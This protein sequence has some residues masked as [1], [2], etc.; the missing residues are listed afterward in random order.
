MT[1]ARLTRLEVASGLVLGTERRRWAKGGAE[2]PRA[3][4]ERSLLPALR[5]SPCLV[6]FS[7]GRDS[8]AV[9]AVATLVA[10][11]ESLPDPIPATLRF[12]SAAES[13]ESEWQEQVV[14]HLGLTDWIRI[15][16]TAELDCVGPV[17]TAALAEHGLLWPCN[18]H[19]HV[20][21]IESARGGSLL[22]GIGGDELL[23]P[24]RWWY[25]RRV[26]GRR[27]RFRPR[28]LLAIGLALAPPAL[29]RPVLRRKTTVPYPWLRPDAVAELERGLADDEAAEPFG[30]RR[31]IEWRADR[32]DLHVG[33][34]SLVA[35]GRADDV[36]LSHPLFGE[37]FASALAAHTG[38]SR[39]RSRQEAMDA[40]FGD[41]LP[42]PVR[43]R[44]TKAS[45]DGAFWHEHSR[46]LVARWNGD[47]VDRDLVDPEALREEWLKG[48][49][50]PRTYTLL[51]SVKL[52]VDLAGGS[53]DEGRKQPA[54]GLLEPPPAV[55]AAELPA[56]QAGEL[57]EPLRTRRRDAQA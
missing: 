11:R 28:D 2:S 54:A 12:P 25:A 31:R 7:G 30:W 19:F 1:V 45:F 36:V 49:P 33:P 35:L 4:F 9:L 8:S 24:T 21:V 44:S 43:A 40:L 50:D 17:A 13:A 34:A 55:G 52:A 10:R 32:R 20:P 23:G 16:R 37:E 53:A 38:A 15:E 46:E 5:R 6:S 42:P 57:E 3:A 51:Q 22:T 47:G 26:L 18:A 27:E 56:G 14:H 48:T 39:F 29:R 41:V